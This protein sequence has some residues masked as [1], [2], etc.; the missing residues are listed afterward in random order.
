LYIVVYT[1]RKPLLEVSQEQN[2]LKRLFFRFALRFAMFL[3]I[4]SLTAC[5][6]AGATQTP[7]A[8]ANMLISAEATNAPTQKPTQEPIAAIVN[9]GV[10]TLAALDRQVNR[11]LEG[12]RS[13]DDPPPADLN[14]FRMAEL[15]SMIDQLLIEQAAA[16][17]G[18]T[19][20]D[21]D[22]E[23]ELQTTI[24]I[25][26][27]QEKW[28][29]QLASDR[30]TEDEYRAGLRSALLTQ[31]MRDIVTAKIGPTSE[32]VHARHIL[33]A[34]ETTANEIANRLKAKG[35]FAQLAGQYSLDVTTKQTGGDLGWFSRGQLLQQ[36]VED[37][38]F[39]LEA[40]QL[41]GP[42][43]SDLGYHIVQTLERAKDRPIDPATRAKLTEEAFEQWVQSLRKS[44]RIQKFP[45]G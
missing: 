31:K 15:D 36:A 21:A 2:S 9:D 28:Q 37:A 13:L 43:K 42:V 1:C 25:A 3:T 29:A 38:A 11:R 14:A 44:A 8:A 4:L 30:M 40:N 23:A 27:S 24:Q 10:I 18:V 20:T 45:N 34:D 22:V 16:I 26:G 17:Q 41:S 5:A 39:S 35:D 7:P 19:V 6:S 32:Q 12:I 33:V